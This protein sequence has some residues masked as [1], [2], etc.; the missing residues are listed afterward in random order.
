M[1]RAPG[2]PPLRHPAISVKLRIHYSEAAARHHP[3]HNN[4]LVCVAPQ[5]R[6]LLRGSSIR[7]RCKLLITASVALRQG[8]IGKDGI[9]S[10]TYRCKSRDGRPNAP[11]GE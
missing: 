10:F 6:N 3:L 8:R 4:K 11:V 5:Y 7:H 9:R 2:W 1:T